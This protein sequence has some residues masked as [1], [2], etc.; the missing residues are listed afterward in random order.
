M[1][2]ITCLSV[3]VLDQ[4]SKYLVVHFLALGHAKPLAPFFSLVHVRNHGVSFSLLSS[5]D[6][7]WGLVVLASIIVLYIASLWKKSDH[8]WQRMAYGAIVGG[9]LG[10]IID[11]TLRGSVVDFIYFHI[12]PYGYPAFNVADSAI[13][14]GVLWLF[15]RQWNDQQ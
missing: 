15:W 3:F 7:R 10:N 6:M 12:G 11:R 13:V 8:T 1:G 5:Y 14:C 2:L 9:A 4:L